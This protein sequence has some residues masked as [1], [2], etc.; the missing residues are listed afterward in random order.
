MEVQK[1]RMEGQEESLAFSLHNV[2]H[3]YMI[4]LSE[5]LD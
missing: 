3:L 5:T 4:R 1:V 2:T